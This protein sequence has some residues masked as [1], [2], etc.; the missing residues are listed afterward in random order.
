MG[1]FV[2]GSV[3]VVVKLPG[4]VEDSV[5]APHIAAV[6]ESALQQTLAYG[7]ASA[8]FFPSSAPSCFSSSAAVPFLGTESPVK[9]LEVNRRNLLLVMKGLPGFLNQR[10][11]L[12]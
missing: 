3:A 4:K 9:V 5:M 1:C 11:L 6:R 12:R 10:E 8:G 7:V 2:G